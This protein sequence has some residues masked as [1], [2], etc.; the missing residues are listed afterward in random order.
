MIEN[1][2]DKYGGLK[3]INDKDKDELRVSWNFGSSNHSCY[4]YDR[5][6]DVRVV[7]FE[8]IQDNPSGLTY[9]FEALNAQEVKILRDKLNNMLNEL[10]AE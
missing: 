8:I 3:F 10:G 6:H 2:F 5:D 4:E 9:A 1:N 7:F